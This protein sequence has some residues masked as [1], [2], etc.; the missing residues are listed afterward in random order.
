MFVTL[1]ALDVLRNAGV[2]PLELLLRHV[3]GDW[4]NLSDS[5]RQQNDLSIEAGLHVL[6]SYVLPNQQTVWL[7]TEWDRSATTV[8]LPDDY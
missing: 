8:L 1:A 5:D 2:S 6:S 4:G 7:I 3:S